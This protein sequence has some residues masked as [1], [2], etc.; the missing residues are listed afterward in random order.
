MLISD[1]QSR[2]AQ[3]FER[4]AKSPPL[5]M[6]YPPVSTGQ[7]YDG[8]PDA[9]ALW[10]GTASSGTLYV[11]VPF[12]QTRCVFCPFYAVVGKES[13]FAGYV[14]DVLAEAALV[15]PAVRHIRFTS[16]YFG[17]GAP[18]VFPTKLIARLISGLGSMF[19]IE[20]ADIS[21]E[22]HPA[23]VGREWLREICAAGVTRLSLGVQ[24]F[25][26]RVLA[27]C[28]RD[29]TVDRV[30][31]AVEAAMDAPL[32]DLNV[33][34]MYGLPEQDFD[35]WNS[36]LREAARLGVPGL[37]LYATVYIPALQ[38]RCEERSFSV[39]DAAQRLAMYNMAYDYLTT[40]GY[41]QPHFGAGAFLRRGLNPH[42][43]NVS[44]GL[45]ML[46][47]GTWAYSSSGAFAHHNLAP[48]A[49]WAQRVR[50]GRLPIRQL[51]PV[52]E[53]ER[54][55][56]YVIEALLLAYVSLDHF[57][58]TFGRGLAETFPDELAVLEREGLARVDAGELRLTRKGGHHLREIRYLFASDEVVHALESGAAQ[59]L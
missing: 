18:S 8:R 4:A 58:E 32:R 14:E 37:T 40:A 2:L 57:R 26:R 44:L 50:E 47:L 29:D 15:A 49:D 25:D 6:L 52:P 51:L 45:P 55:R 17:G 13:E 36:D 35:S 56:K 38:A 20:G 19:R 33:D 22:A 31:P 23:H 59:G 54:T 3:R 10:A 53:R 21:L 27:A 16:I 5:M 30:L 24:S 42:R 39:P 7:P 28:G 12:C 46:G 43:R 11:H 1:A 34:L 41:P 9:A 48:T